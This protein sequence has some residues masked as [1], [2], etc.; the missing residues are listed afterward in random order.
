MKILWYK[1]SFDNK[2]LE[3]F[4]DPDKLICKI[5]CEIGQSI[6]ELIETWFQ[7]NNIQIDFDQLIPL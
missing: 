2:T 4:S 1:I 6:L 3:V 7:E 5:P